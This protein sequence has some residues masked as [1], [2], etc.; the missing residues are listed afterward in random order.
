LT[1]KSNH[2]VFVPNCTWVVPLIKFPQAVCEILCSWTF[3]IQPHRHRYTRICSLKTEYFRRLIANEGREIQTNKCSFPT[4]MHV[5]HALQ[6]PSMCITACIGFKVLISL[7]KTT[8]HIETLTFPRLDRKKTSQFTCRRRSQL[9]TGHKPLPAASVHAAEETLG[10]ILGQEWPTVI[11]LY[12]DPTQQPATTYDMYSSSEKY[13]S[14]PNNMYWL[15]HISNITCHIDNIQK[16]HILQKYMRLF[17][18]QTPVTTCPIVWSSALYASNFCCSNWAN[19]TFLSNSLQT[20]TERH[21]FQL[22]HFT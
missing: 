17:H 22:E 11:D 16:K 21:S 6:H 1:S 13:K 14:F 7:L 3:R 5:M 20:K 4:G 15:I 2:F 12:R 19:S 18:L 10:Q 9:A 8:L